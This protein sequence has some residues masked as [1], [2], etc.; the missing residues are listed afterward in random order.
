MTQRG[1]TLILFSPPTHPWLDDDIDRRVRFWEYVRVNF[2]RIVPDVPAECDVD[3]MA[4]GHPHRDGPV[5]TLGV[6]A[7]AAVADSVPDPDWM[8]DVVTAWCEKLSPSEIESIVSRT[9]SPT[10]G[11]LVQIRVHPRR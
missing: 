3:I 9:E 11:E 10:W 6:H 8:T 5:L 2:H 7:P 4:S 1:Y